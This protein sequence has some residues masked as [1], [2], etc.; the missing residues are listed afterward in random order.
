MQSPFL[1]SVIIT[2]MIL[3][4]GPSGRTERISY[5][6]VK[7][8]AHKLGFELSLLGKYVTRVQELEESYRQAEVKPRDG[9]ALVQEI[10]KDIGFLMESKI[11]AVKRIMDVAES[12]AENA[13]ND[14]KPPVMYHNAKDNNLTMTYSA[15][16]GRRV[17]LNYSNFHI[18]TNVYNQSYNVVTAITWAQKLNTTFMNNYDLDPSLSWQYFG[19]STG[20][21]MQYPAISWNMEPVDLFDCRTRNWYIEAA[22]SPKDILI[23]VDN[24]GSMTGIR[25]EIARH[26]VNSIL[27]TL[28]NN[29]FVNV[30][31]FSN[32]THEVVACFNNTLVQANLANIRELKTAMECVDTDKIANFSI[33]LRQAFELLE[34]FREQRK[35][36]LCNQAIMLVT[37]GVPENYKEIF[38]TYNWRANSDDPDMGDMPVRVFTY[39][40]GREVPDVRDVR[41]MACANRGYYVHLSTMAEVSEKVLNYIPVMA[42]PLVLRRT[43]HPVIWTPVY[44]D[45]TD[46]I[47]TDWLW[48]QRE[49]SYQRELVETHRIHN[50]ETRQ[51]L[52]NLRE[53]RERRFVQKH[54]RTYDQDDDLQEYRLMT[55]VSVPVFNRRPNANI[56]EQVLV[57]GAY[58]VTKTR[59]TRIAELLGVAGIDVPIKEIE[60]LMLPHMLGVN[61]YAF[62]V[63]NNGYILIHP[64]LR[65]VF[66][67]ILKPAY[68]SVDM[69]EV[70]LIDDGTIPRN[71]SKSLLQF[72]DLVINQS[73]GMTTLHTKY[74]YDDMQRVG[75]MRRDYFYTGINNTPFTV[76]V[77]LPVH[78]HGGSYRVHAIEEIH[79]YQHQRDK[80]ATDYFSGSNWRVH[81]DWTYC[82]YHYD[83][84]HSFS[85]PEEELLHF[86]R[87][88]RVPGWKWMDMNRVGSHP[89]EHSHSGSSR[90]NTS[91]VERTSYYCDRNLLLSL[92]FDAMVT[93]WFANASTVREEKGP[94]AMLMNLLSRKELQQRFGFTLAFVATHSGLTRWQDFPIEN[95]TQPED[96]FG[97]LHP[98]AIDEV[99]YKRAVEQYYVQPD[100]FVFSVPIDDAGADN[101]T[102]VTASHAIFIGKM[103]APAAVV[104]F[105]FKHSKLQSLFRNITY[106]CEGL[107][108]CQRSCEDEGLHCYLVDNNGY[109][110]AGENSSDAGKFFGQ[111]NKHVM[112]SLVENGIFDEIEIYD[113]QAVCFRD[114]K[115]ICSHGNILL[116]PLK[117]LERAANWVLGSLAWI[118]VKSGIWSSAD[119][120]YAYPYP[121]DDDDE[122]I[123]EETVDE[124][125]EEDGIMVEEVKSKPD[126]PDE[127]ANAEKSHETSDQ[128]RNDEEPNAE[129]KGEKDNQPPQIKRTRPETCDQRMKLYLLQNVSADK[130]D[131]DC[132]SVGD[133]ERDCERPYVVQPVDSSNMILLVVDAICLKSDAEKLTVAPKEVEDYKDSLACYKA[134]NSLPRR[135]P[136]SCI[137]NHTKEREIKD[138]CGGA[139]RGIGIT[140]LSMLLP[141]LLTVPSSL[142]AFF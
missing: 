41:W 118:W 125:E 80:D 3:A 32:E 140:L 83:G 107:G 104:G 46:P 67:N 51:R 134:T 111:I 15:H 63:T 76:V 131:I 2:L 44:A 93:E 8:W 49:R 95:D 61:G 7:S 14:V 57:N 26:V 11:S 142:F 97:K 16:F 36:T 77:S 138:L 29:D 98:R 74:H 52:M 141:I 100:S 12:L 13:S 43:D 17:N 114:E 48:E 23:L 110:V 87:R 136:D 66:R 106:S 119:Y 128:D 81:P 75:R 94:L 88:T 130:Y 90:V 116:T 6:T 122:Q 54:K 53:E 121:K 58:W 113:Y 115:K 101:E 60:K 40:I 137:R 33:V 139:S 55:T 127:K 91:K 19:S 124:D 50:P 25:K 120:A 1:T 105:Q 45:V 64:D 47:M 126:V 85:T 68:N 103:K 21:M 69:A 79:R 109:V 62:I 37:D 73:S 72:R 65:P 20:F 123:D 39:L 133:V 31:K 99:W 38:A 108:N 70:E 22:A 96:H 82:G 112:L 4:E 86:L 84:D 18:P 117:T 35:G 92:V 129:T 5:N 89:P 71:F 135:R 78:G 59:E 102:F 56:T 24:S 42:R 27:D 132:V 28:G 30:I 10:A 34:N 9:A